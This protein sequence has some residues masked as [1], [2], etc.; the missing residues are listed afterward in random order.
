MI[1]LTERE[2]YFFLECCDGA[3]LI[4]VDKVEV[5]IACLFLTYKG[6]H[7]G[8]VTLAGRAVIL[9][10]AKEIGIEVVGEELL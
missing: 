2:G 4:Q 9:Y 7:R 10:Q 8:T 5:S 3:F 6:S 1:K